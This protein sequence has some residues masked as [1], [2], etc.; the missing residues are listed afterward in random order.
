MNWNKC[1]P[2]SAACQSNISLFFVDV[3]KQLKLSENYIDIYNKTKTYKN[4][5]N[6]TKWLHF[7][8]KYTKS[9]F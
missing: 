9:K 8:I 5:K 1:K 3:L 2:V 4:D 7:N 6:T